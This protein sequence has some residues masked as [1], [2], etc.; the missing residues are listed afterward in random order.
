MVMMLLLLLVIKVRTVE[1]TWC[2]MVHWALFT[3][4]GSED[5]N[6][7][8]IICS[9]TT[10]T[11]WTSTHGPYT[12]HTRKSPHTRDPCTCQCDVGC[13]RIVYF[14]ALNIQFLSDI[15]RNYQIARLV[16]AELKEMRRKCYRVKNCE[17]SFGCSY[18]ASFRVL[19][20]IAPRH[21]LNRM[22]S[23][24]KGKKFQFLASFA[25]K[26]ASDWLTGFAHAHQ[27]LAPAL[28][29]GSSVWL[30]MSNWMEIHSPDNLGAM[31]SST[32]ITLRVNGPLMLCHGNKPF[33]GNYSSV[34]LTCTIPPLCV[35]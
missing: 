21:E 33:V 9:F 3:L 24:K 35:F 18:W 5:D 34:L 19:D 6:A 17:A 23:I 10:V 8:F 26:M 4:A 25:G 20:C 15:P 27:C 12:S 13:P 16:H 2:H 14:T 29:W 31:Q 7:M 1:N 30:K 22:N 32:R 28:W 11:F